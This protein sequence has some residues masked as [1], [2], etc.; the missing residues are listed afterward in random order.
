MAA[1][2]GNP[3]TVNLL[4]TRQDID[5]NEKSILNQFICFISFL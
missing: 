3:D 2:I 4:L 1:D 5:V